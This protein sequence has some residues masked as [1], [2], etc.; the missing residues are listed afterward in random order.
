MKLLFYVVSSMTGIV[1]VNHA[2]PRLT[3]WSHYLTFA[4]AAYGVGSIAN[5][6]YQAI[7]K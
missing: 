4:F 3:R 1:V 6:L 7:V 2:M 5:D